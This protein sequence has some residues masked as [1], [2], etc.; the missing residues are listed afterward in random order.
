MTLLVVQ[1]V[2]IIN[3]SDKIRALFL[4]IFLWCAPKCVTASNLKTAIFR[5]HYLHIFQ[6][7]LANL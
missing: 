4:V 6:L 7:R 2:R 5:I 3:F 1:A